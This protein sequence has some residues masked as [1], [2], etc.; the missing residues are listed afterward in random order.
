MSRQ[1]LITTAVLFVQAPSNSYL[2]PAL[3]LVGRYRRSARY[4]RRGSLKI[5]LGIVEKEKLL[6]ARH[7]SI[8]VRVAH[9]SSRHADIFP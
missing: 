7:I 1:D 6:C 9:L 2:G 3:F 8:R 5:L 4:L